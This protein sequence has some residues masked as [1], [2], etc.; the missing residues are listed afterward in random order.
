MTTS[1]RIHKTE[2]TWSIRAGGAVLGE[3]SAALELTEGARTPVL[4]F[5]R[6]DIAMAF[7]E[8]S[9]HTTVCPNKGTASYFSIVLRSKTLKNA[10]W[11]FDTPTDAARRLS[12]YLAFD[13]EHVT[14]EET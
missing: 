11:S 5:P 12:G 14:V 2:G 9:K 10:A 7:L 6:D 13:P 3:S 1:L 4:Y 8:P